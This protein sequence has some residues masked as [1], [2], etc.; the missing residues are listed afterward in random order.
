MSAT[1]SASS[2]GLP[3]RVIAQGHEAVP[4]CEMTRWNRPVTSVMMAVTVG[5]TGFALPQYKAS[6]HYCLMVWRWHG[7]VAG[8]L[9]NTQATICESTT[10]G[11]LRSLLLR[12]HAH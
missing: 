10:G 8:T 9:S 2:F 1:C 7:L 3:G 11:R 6:P 12:A 4:L 5:S